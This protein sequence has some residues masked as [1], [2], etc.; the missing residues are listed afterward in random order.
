MATPIAP[1]PQT[2]LNVAFITGSGHRKLRM[3]LPLQYKTDN[4]QGHIT[5]GLKAP[6]INSHIQG[7]K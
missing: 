4:Q 1:L 2:I 7:M 5:E 6:V 3:A